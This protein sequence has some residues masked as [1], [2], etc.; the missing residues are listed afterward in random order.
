MRRSPTIRSCNGCFLKHEESQ[1]TEQLKTGV[2][3]VL[4]YA[5]NIGAMG[6]T[7]LSPL[8]L[9]FF[10]TIELVKLACVCNNCF[11]I[12]PFGWYFKDL[13]YFAMKFINTFGVVMEAQTFI[14]VEN[15][16]ITTIRYYS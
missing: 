16:V 8:I 11:W 1:L 12:H 15:T 7:L 3:T 10:F 14:A 2:I 6:L 13:Q 4:Q 9:S 5:G